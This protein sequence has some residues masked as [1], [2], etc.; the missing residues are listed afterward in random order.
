[1]CG[2]GNAAW[3]ERENKRRR[4]T[5]ATLGEGEGEG[6]REGR[7]RGKGRGAQEVAVEVEEGGGKEGT[8]KEIREEE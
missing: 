2:D 7:E 1:L 6:S 4:C 5:G 3:G 8:W